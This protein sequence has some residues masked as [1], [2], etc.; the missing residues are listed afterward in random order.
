MDALEYTARCWSA[1]GRILAA[2]ARYEER[3]GLDP[4]LLDSVDAKVTAFSRDP[5][6]EAAKTE[7][8]V[9]LA[10]FLAAALQAAD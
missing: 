10:T 9:A 6:D 2:C 4:S 7:L 5:H 1:S 8:A 3:Y